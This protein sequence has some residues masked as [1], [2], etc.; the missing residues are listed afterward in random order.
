MTSHCFFL[1]KEVARRCSVRR[2][3]LFRFDLRC[4]NVSLFTVRPAHFSYFYF[5]LLGALLC[6]SVEAEPHWPTPAIPDNVH[7]FAIGN[8]LTIDGLPMQLRGFVSS[9][10]AA[11]LIDAWRRK[12]GSP[13]A[14]NTVGKFRVLGKADQGFYITVQIQAADNGSRGTISVA[15]LATFARSRDER[16]RSTAHLLDRLPSGSSIASQMSSIEGTNSTR[17]I[18]VVNTHSEG[19]NRDALM[20]LMREDGYVL[21]KD[22]APDAAARRNLSSQI[23]AA[24]AL[25]FKAPDREAVAMIVRNG[26]KTALV[27]N[28]TTNL[29][30]FK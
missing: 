8:Q 5:A 6:T 1:F 30:S 20:S 11:D 2:R 4:I 28:T 23:A 27:L 24:H 13:L 3:T 12:L 17:H 7:L 18:V 10:S 16:Q 29:Q 19:L 25:F 21:E 26:D 14:E 22:I 9:R 15:D